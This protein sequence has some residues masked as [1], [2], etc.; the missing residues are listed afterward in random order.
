MRYSIFIELEPF[1]GSASRPTQQTTP[2]D[3]ANEEAALKDAQA[4]FED[5]FSEAPHVK[6]ARAHVQRPDGT[7][8]REFTKSRGKPD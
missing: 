7:V 3:A 4:Y 2:I 1:E 5:I 8:A 6:L